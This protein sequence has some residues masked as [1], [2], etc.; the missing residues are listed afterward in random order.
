MTSDGKSTPQ[1]WVDT[2]RSAVNR[3]FY[4]DNLNIMS[5]ELGKGSV[6]LIYLDPPFNS[7]HNY[8][9]MYGK[10]RGALV[11]EQIHAFSDTWTLDREKEEVARS[12]PLLMKD[13]GV[14]DLYIEFWRVWMEALRRTQ[15]KL[16]A[17]LVYMVQ[18][19]LY[20]RSILTPQGSIYFH[21]DPTA[22]HYLKVMMDGIFGHDNFRNEIIWKRTSSHNRAQRW[23]DVH[24]TLLF[25]SR[26]DRFT[27]NAVE[28]P[29]SEAYVSSKY[30]HE[31]ELGRH[32]YSDLTA[33]G[34][35]GGDSGQ[36]WQG[37]DPSSI[38]RHWAIPQ[39]T[40]DLLEGR[41]VSPPRGVTSQL[42]ALLEH[43]FIR[44]T[45]GREGRS[46]TPEIKHYLQEGQ[47]VQDL[48]L[49]IPPLN[50]M[51]DERLGYPTQKPIA[52]LDRIIRASSNPGDV[53]FDP[54]CGC[55]TTIYAA[56]INKRKWI[57]C[58]IAILPVRIVRKTLKGRYGLE[59]GRDFVV[60]GIPVNTYQAEDLAIRDQR[61][62][63]SWA[64]ELVGGLPLAQTDDEFFDGCIFSQVEDDTSI[65]PLAVR[66]SVR[67]A[68]VRRVHEYLATRPDVPAAG[69]ISLHDPSRVT[70]LELNR[71]LKE[72]IGDPTPIQ[73]L[74][75]R[76]L[77]EE[78]RGFVTPTGAWTQ[79]LNP[80]QGKFL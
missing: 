74:T 40:R 32:R 5:K 78:K 3:L 72:R 54:F 39:R 26:S 6:D 56:H 58:D 7:Q 46:G 24:D 41:G 70:L 33:P 37:F 80:A 20:M 27:W 73:L 21:C 68:D 61:Q 43:G 23:G 4:G 51:S 16:L 44:L 62:F 19:L 34:I 63:R 10:H 77:L 15:P 67:P 14:S 50:A 60:S 35:R 52:L 36:E 31:D 55:G 75:V 76:E 66:E 25:Y 47:P 71:L 30:R 64:V 17:Y 48:I 38:G 42:D 13:Q 59:E 49:D 9:V 65:F 45:Q 18:R 53:V 11:P 69:I 22:S 2:S 28:Q 79:T 57:G 29:L 8:N 12:M 1:S